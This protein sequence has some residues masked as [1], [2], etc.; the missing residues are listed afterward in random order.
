MPKRGPH[1]KKRIDRRIAHP[2]IRC[3]FVCVWD[4]RPLTRTH[5]R[6]RFISVWK[7]LKPR[8]YRLHTVYL[9]G[10]PEFNLR[11]PPSRTPAEEPDC[12]TKD[13]F[14][15]L[16]FSPAWWVS[17][18]PRHLPKKYGTK[19]KR[20]LNSFFALSRISRNY[21]IARPLNPPTVCFYR[22]KA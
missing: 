4:S 9:R 15:V 11:P 10:W 5:T 2:L 3:M 1:P 21:F 14:S 17:L 12:H 20:L 19:A 18:A 16:S 6:E 8:D 7:M 13:I 22:E